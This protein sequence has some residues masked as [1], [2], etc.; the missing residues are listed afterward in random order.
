MWGLGQIIFLSWFA[1]CVVPA[2]LG[3]A[4]RAYLLKK[5]A[6][7]GFSKTIGTILAERI[8]DMIILFV[9]LAG[10]ALLV[11]RGKN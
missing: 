9:L 11:I 6:N 3:D 1:N 10:A 2:K 4:Y 7:V 8:I 5:D